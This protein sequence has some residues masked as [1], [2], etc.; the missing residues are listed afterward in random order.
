M[1]VFGALADSTRRALLIRLASGPARVVDLSTDHA[2]SRP[3]ISKHLRVLGEAGL[4][5]AVDV[6][7]ERHYRA[8]VPPLAQ[9]REFLEQV[10]RLPARP[11][12]AVAVAAPTAAPSPPFGEGAL[13][14]LDLEVRRVGRD[15]EH[16]RA[17]L[18]P[19]APQPRED[20]A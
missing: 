11:D 18:A 19:N 1:D 5:D 17:G 8:L 20:T 15:R 14:G 4:V 12:R 13:A 7:R 2:I 3:A 6:G 9:V 16:V 10:D